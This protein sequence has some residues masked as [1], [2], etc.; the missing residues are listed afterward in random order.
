MP[1]PN[2]KNFSTP[3]NNR[4]NIRKHNKKMKKNMLDKKHMLKYSLGDT[5]TSACFRCSFRNGNT[6]S[7]DSPMPKKELETDFKVF[8]GNIE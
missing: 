1:N 6:P 4:I 5:S 7:N 2:K 8:I 3:A